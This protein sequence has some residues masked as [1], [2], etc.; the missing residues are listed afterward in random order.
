[1]GM[2]WTCVQFL[3]SQCHKSW[4]PKLPLFILCVCVC[5]GPHLRYM[6]VSRLGIEWELQLPAYTTTTA[7]ATPDRSQVW[8]LH[9]T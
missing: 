7:I 1:M 6:E 9:R 3:Q 2:K 4:V 5:L 8:E